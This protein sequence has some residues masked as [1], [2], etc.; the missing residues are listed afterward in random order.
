MLCHWASP[1]HSLNTAMFMFKNIS[2]SCSS[3]KTNL[4]HIRFE[5]TQ[6]VWAEE[7]MEFRHL[8]LLGDVREFILELG[9]VVEL[10]ATHEVEEME[11]FFQIILKRSPRQQQLVGY[12]V[13]RQVPEEL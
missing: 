2:L 5:T 10:V 1:A 9:Q 8:L 12:V 6:H 4:K 13:V 11:Q 7:V 3:V